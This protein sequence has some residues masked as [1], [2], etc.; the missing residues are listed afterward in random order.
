MTACLP[1]EFEVK[2]LPKQFYLFLLSKAKNYNLVSS[3]LQLTLI[4]S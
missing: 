3:L 1:Q 4:W 2:E